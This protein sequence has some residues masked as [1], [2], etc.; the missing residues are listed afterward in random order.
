MK[1][2]SLLFDLQSR[3]LSMVLPIVTGCMLAQAVASSPEGVRFSIVGDWEI[4]ATAKNPPITGDNRLKIDPVGMATVVDEVHPSLPLFNAQAAGWAKGLRPMQLR[5]QEIATPG[6]LVPGSMKVSTSEP[7]PRVLERGKDYEI[8]ELWGT[9]GRL[10]DGT[11]ADG[12]AVKLEYQYHPLRLDSVVVDGSGRLKLL[13]GATRAAAPLSPEP[14]QGE[15]LLG[16]IWFP[17]KV[18][19][20]GNANL[21]PVLETEFPEP[22]GLSAET[23]AKLP[24][25]L[26][27]LKSG[28]K[29]KILAWGDSVTESTYLPNRDQDAWQ[30]QFVKRLKEKYPQANIEL[31]TEAWGGR[32]TG[33]YLA[34][35]PGSLHNYQEKVL[36][37]KPDLIVSEFVNDSGLNTQQVNERYGKLLADFQAIGTEW[38]ILTPHY[39]YTGWMGYESEREVDDDSR[40]YVKALRE[41][42]KVNPVVIADASARYGRLWRQGLPYSSLMLN[43]LNHPDARGMKIFA[44][45]LIAVFP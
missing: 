16:R 12:Q 28:E 22:A 37:V 8:D 23:P 38:I 20:L 43:S 9:L 4:Q 17:G 27:K 40:E 24:R 35:P 42:G 10:E 6:I 2:L 19:Q 26:A 39:T 41:F 29:L 44:D 21:F 15:Q 30:H 7:S 25:T 34:E 14:A 31:V 33:S 11:L 13:K 45:A 18:D 1:G 5:G 3:A 36:A 32:N